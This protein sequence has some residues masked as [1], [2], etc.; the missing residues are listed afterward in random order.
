MNLNLPDYDFR[1]RRDNE[2]VKIFDRLRRKF[3]MLTPEEWVRQ[4]FIEFLISEKGYPASL[5]ANEVGITLNGTRRRCDSV[6]FDRNG[7]V[8]LIIE[9]K[10]P[11]VKLSQLTFDQIVRYNMVLHADLLMVSN[12]LN[13]YCCRIDYDS[14]TYSFLK[15]LPDYKDLK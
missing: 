15:E 6:M 8:V 2:G 4:H 1:L 14:A 7:R 13:H 12:G 3:V 9:Y 10:A 11:G 5:M